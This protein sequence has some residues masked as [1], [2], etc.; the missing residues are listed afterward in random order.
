[1]AKQQANGAQIK[2]LPATRHDNTVKTKQ[3]NVRMEY[4]WGAITISGAAASGVQEVVAYDAP[5]TE[6]PTVT[7]TFGGDQTSGAEA[8]GS[9]QNTI[10]GFA[11]AKVTGLSVNGFNAYLWT[12]SGTWPVGAVVYY[13]WMAVG[14]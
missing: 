4:G 2:N 1:M 13:H 8:L 11:A 5:F 10:H 14:R 9:G 12:P 7:L 6:I 3:T